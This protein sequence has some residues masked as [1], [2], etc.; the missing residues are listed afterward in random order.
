MSILIGQNSYITIAEADSFI[1]ENYISTDTQRVAW[2]ALNDSN[3]EVYLRNATSSMERL[4]FIGQ[5]YADD[6]SLSFP[7]V[8]HDFY[9][10]E[11]PQDI[12][13][14]QA[15]ESLELAS[16]TQDTEIAKGYA[17]NVKNYSIGQLSE[18]YK[19]YNASSMQAILMS[20]KAQRL[21]RGFL[22]GGYGVQ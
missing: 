13:D 14:A 2:E 15:L 16:P 18:T 12:K 1:G 7:R 8:F 5:K 9:Q 22:G 4:L 21:L 10:E 6:Q 3:K 19:S 17:S 11:V 20:Q